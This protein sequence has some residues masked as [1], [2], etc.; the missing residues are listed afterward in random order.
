MLELAGNS[1]TGDVNDKKEKAI[2]REQSL[3]QLRHDKTSPRG[4]HVIKKEVAGFVTSAFTATFKEGSR[5][6]QTRK[7]ER[8][9]SRST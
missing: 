7:G 5:Q 9:K 4:F 1:R 8:G 6:E 3:P 2:R